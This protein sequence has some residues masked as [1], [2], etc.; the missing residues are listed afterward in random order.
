MLAGVCSLLSASRASDWDLESPAALIN[1]FT[2][3]VMSHALRSSLE[4]RIT[5]RN[6]LSLEF[7]RLLG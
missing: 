6:K 3:D 1:A 4:S 2:R 7:C 5:C